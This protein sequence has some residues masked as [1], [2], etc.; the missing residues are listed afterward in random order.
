MSNNYAA[1][2][3]PFATQPQPSLTMGMPENSKHG[4]TSITHATERFQGSKFNI[5]SQHCLYPRLDFAAN[6]L[7]GG[8]YERALMK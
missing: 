7:W 2:S 5:T 1:G 4:I 3:L 8:C 6:S